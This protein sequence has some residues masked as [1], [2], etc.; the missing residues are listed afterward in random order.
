MLGMGWWRKTGGV[1]SDQRGGR[2]SRW[3]LAAH[4]HRRSDIAA[5]WGEGFALGLAAHS[6]GRR[7][8]RRALG[9]FARIHW[10]FIRIGDPISPLLGERASRSAL[11]THSQCRRPTSPRLR[12]PG[13][14]RRARGVCGIPLGFG[15]YWISDFRFPSSVFRLL[16]SVFH[17]P[18][19]GTNAEPHE[20]ARVGGCWSGGS[21]G[22]GCGTIIMIH[23]A[24]VGH[25]GRTT[26]P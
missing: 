14:R 3:T 26:A 4:S 15:R 22:D 11:A 5:P 12:R 20:L 6:Q 23:G 24:D 25:V 10:R 21:V 1:R 18:H 9:S 7:G 19:S 17:S 2:A 8:R 16:S 13:G